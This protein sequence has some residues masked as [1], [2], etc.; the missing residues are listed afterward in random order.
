MN[1]QNVWRIDLERLPRG[2]LLV[3]RSQAVQIIGKRAD[4]MIPYLAERG[5]IKRYRLG[6]VWGYLVSGLR[7][8]A[9]SKGRQLDEDLVARY[10]LP[11][12]TIRSYPTD[13]IPAAEASVLLG[14]DVQ[15]GYLRRLRREG[16]LQG[17]WLLSE[18]GY[19]KA[20]L[21]SLDVGRS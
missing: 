12:D 19:S 7:A 17:Y 6:R 20:E 2:D 14:V 10:G 21:A 18:H 5:R 13:L 4:S 16:R 15:A 9:A 1:E 3:T 8:Y 11:T